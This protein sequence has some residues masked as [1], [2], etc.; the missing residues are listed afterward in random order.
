VLLLFVAALWL[1][2]GSVTML[3]PLRAFSREMGAALLC[4]VRES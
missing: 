2:M 1:P 4:S 3:C